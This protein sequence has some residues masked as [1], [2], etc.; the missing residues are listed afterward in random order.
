VYAFLKILCRLTLLGYFK[1]IKIS[2]REHLK[3]DGPYIFVANHPSAFM[4]PIAVATS[5]KQTVY[6]LAAGEYMGKGLKFKFMNKVLH[7]IPI[8]RPSTMPG[9]THKNKAIFSKCTEHLLRK[10]C[11]LVFPEGVSVTERKIL[12]LKTGV[13]RIART[14]ELEADFKAKVKIVPVGLN[15]SDPHTFRSDLFI[16]IGKPIH[17]KDF[18]SKSEEKEMIQEEVKALTNHI[19]EK[20]IDSILHHEEAEMEFL[21]ERLNASYSNELHEE[22]NIDFSDQEAAFKLDKLTIDAIKHFKIEDESAYK[23]MKEQVKSYVHL[24]KNQG[25]KDRDLTKYQTPYSAV[26]ILYLIIGLPFFTLGYLGNFIPFIINDRI[27]KMINNQDSFQG[28]LKMGIGLFI[29]LLYYIALVIVLWMLTP[30]GFISLLIPFIL[31]LSGTYALIY[32]KVFNVIKRR[33]NLKKTFKEQ[34]HLASDI[35]QER[36]LLYAKLQAFRKAYDNRA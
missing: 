3:E 23:N 25:I 22:L 13:A 28:S 11:L 4:D 2:G 10:R 30:L 15:Y 1:R 7:M 18:F 31:Y 29:F 21:M 17:A 35:L 24:L 6:F 9:D 16:N 32:R 19:E 27:Q 36:D 8:Y 34:P 33:M 14:T 20:M 26:Q 12:P 5:I